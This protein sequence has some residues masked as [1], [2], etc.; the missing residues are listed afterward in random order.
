MKRW[1]WYVCGVFCGLVFAGSFG[2]ARLGMASSAA[3][4][5]AAVGSTMASLEKAPPEDGKLRIIAFGAHPDDCEIYAGGVACLWSDLGHHVKFVSTTN[6]DI[7][8]WQTAG[9]PLAL[10]RTAEVQK[11]A[12]I[13]GN[14][15]QVLDIH[16]GEI[17]PT[18]ENRRT[19]TRLIRHWNADIVITH[20]PNDYH[21]DHRYTGI[22]VQDAAYMVT[23]PFFC[24]DVPAIKKNPVFLYASDGFQKPNP[25]R[26]DIVVS[27]DSV[28]ERKLDAMA[29]LVSQFI[30]GGCGGSAGDIPR[31]AADLKARQE[32]LRKGWLRQQHVDLANQYRD[33]LIELYGEE[34]GKK[35][36]YAE[37]FEVCEY[38]R[39]PTKDELR[40]LFPFVPQGK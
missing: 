30:E 25:F 26:P 12:K 7:G 39:S 33:K 17:E 35:V 5:A 14:T 6:G 16:D 37:A 20:R 1:Q 38:G 10:R 21:P 11:A 13:L 3:D 27:I 15:V 34:A 18:L 22:L 19:F 29:E 23:V 28:I 4:V 36:R 2:A 32:Q 40:T 8:H 24:P 9:G 31:D